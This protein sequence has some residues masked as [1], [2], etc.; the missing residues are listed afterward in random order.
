MVYVDPDL[1]VIGGEFQECLM[2]PNM[3]SFKHFCKLNTVTGDYLYDNYK[4]LEGDLVL[5]EFPAYFSL[6]KKDRYW[7]KVTKDI[8]F[9]IIESSLKEYDE[10]IK[11]LKTF[12]DNINKESI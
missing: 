12:R 8:C 7:K 10:K 9:S 3:K 1:Y 11:A 6:R 5:I 4:F 2:F